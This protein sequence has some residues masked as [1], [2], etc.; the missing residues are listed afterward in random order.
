MGKSCRKGGACLGAALLREE[1][2][3]SVRQV[4]EQ[5]RKVRREALRA[6]AE[7]LAAEAGR[8]GVQ[9]VV[10]FGSLARQQVG[11]TTD[12]DLLI[13]WDTPLGFVERTVELYRRL[14][15]RVAV[16]L[17]VYTPAEIRQAAPG[18]LAQRALAEGKVLYET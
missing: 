3:L 2:N 5:R 6:E 7:R 13:I 11:L 16:D 12:V 17:L 15:P 14:R 9:R 18:S 1:S 8:L 10:L 4:L